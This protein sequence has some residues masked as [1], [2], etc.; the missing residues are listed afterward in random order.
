[1]KVYAEVAIKGGDQISKQRTSTDNQGG[2]NPTWNCPMKF[3]IDKTALQ[4]DRLYLVVTLRS[5]GLIVDGDLAEVRMSMMNMIADGTVRLVQHQFGK[6]KSKEAVDQ[7]TA[8]SPAIDPTPTGLSGA[9]TSLGNPPGSS[10]TAPPSLAHVAAGAGY[11]SGYTPNGNGS[12]GYAHQHYHPGLWYLPQHPLQTGYGYLPQLQ[13]YYPVMQ[14]PQKTSLLEFG[15]HVA[16]N[17]LAKVF[18]DRLNDVASN[19]YD[20]GSDAGFDVS[21]FDI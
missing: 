20:S 8:P 15:S 1:M 16:E 2:I 9:T 21:G 12:S 3:I 13:P 11:T 17:V 5:P 18:S 7:Q 19:Y 4:Q 10:I 6:S 14:Q